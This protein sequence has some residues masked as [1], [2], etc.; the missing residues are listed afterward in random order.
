[1]GIA[2]GLLV[3]VAVVCAGSAVGRRFNIPVPL[4]LVLAGVAGSFLPFIPPVEL[5]PELVLVGLLPPLLY[6]A[7]FRTSLFDFKSNRRS[8]GLL[9]VGYVIFGTVGVGLVVWWLFPEIPLAAAIALGAVVAPPDAV[10]ATAIAR[11]VGMPRRIVNILEGE[12][13]VNDATALVCLRAAVAAIAGSVSALDV[14]G[15]FVVAA[16]GGLAVGLA[17]AYLL[18]EVRKRISNVAINTSTSLMAPFVAFLP[19]EAIHASGVLAVVVT[20]LVMGTKAPS[21]PNGAARQS[22]RSNWDTVQFLLENAVFLL[23]GLQVRS[24]IDS[25]QDDSLGAGRVWLGCA[26]IL[27]AVLVL[28]PVWV[29]PATYLPRLIPSVQRKDPAPPW[30]FPAIVSWAGMRGVVTLAAVLTLPDDLEHRNVLVLAAMVVVAGTLVLQGFTLPALVRVLGLPGPDRREDAL[31]Q[32]ALMQLATAAGMERLEQLRR[33]ND[34]PEVMD[35]L[36]RRTQERGLAAWERLGRP[37][38]ES[39][40]PSQRY[41]QLRMAMLEAERDKVLELRRGGDFA[42][43]VLSEVL[44]RLDVEE[45]MLDASLNEPDAATEGGGEGLA[46]PGGVC[47]HLTAAMPSP[48]PANP[49]C[50]GCEREGTTPVHLRMCLACGNIGCCDSSAGRHASRHFKEAGHPVMRSIEPGEDW[51]WCYVD[52]LLG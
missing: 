38:A 8:I 14:A 20:G 47:D 7:A 12:S 40:T 42:H 43:E 51:R 32:A 34:P 36:R 21:M 19:A 31:N 10:A 22:A 18:T 16:G 2:L 1:M 52:D 35:M 28:R 39:A 5:N 4:L 11:K 29:F 30:Q 46:Q 45:S 44:E 25:V 15:G 33:E 23:I 41:A 48:V 9:S 49:T 50:A 6:A 3:I 37:A 24:I 27:L 13:L 26:V 17:A